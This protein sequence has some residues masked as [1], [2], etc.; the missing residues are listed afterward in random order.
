MPASLIF[1]EEQG[2]L[3]CSGD[4]FLIS[5]AGLIPATPESVPDATCDSKA[6][7]LFLQ[8]RG[9]ICDPSDGALP[10]FERTRYE[11]LSLWS[12]QGEAG[13]EAPT[14]NPEGPPTAGHL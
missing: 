1:W 14:E 3:N 12:M 13:P 6:G 9:L 2:I 5:R 7:V 11:Q 10:E 8:T 4:A